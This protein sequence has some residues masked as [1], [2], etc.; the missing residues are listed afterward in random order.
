RP[1]RRSYLDGDV[2]SQGGHSFCAFAVWWRLRRRPANDEPRLGFS[3][4][5]SKIRGEP[6]V[7]FQ[8]ARGVSR[9]VLA[10]RRDDGVRAVAKSVVN[11]ISGPLLAGFDSL[12]ASGRFVQRMLRSA[13]HL[14]R[15][16]EA[17]RGVIYPPLCLVCDA[18]LD[19]RV[20]YFCAGCLAE[21]V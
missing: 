4:Y 3:V 16:L 6:G 13:R 15:P 7:Q 14:S 21:M 20:E 9:A 11:R 1:V 17:V 18:D 8:S 12:R 5:Y 19:D 2:R 10:R